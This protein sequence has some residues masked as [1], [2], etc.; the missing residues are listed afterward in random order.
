M[1]KWFNTLKNNVM[2]CWHGYIPNWTSDM[3]KRE[4]KCVSFLFLLHYQTRCRWPVCIATTPPLFHN[5]YA[6]W[7]YL[8]MTR[9]AF[10]RLFYFWLRRKEVTSVLFG[11]VCS[12]LCVYSTLTFLFVNLNGTYSSASGGGGGSDDEW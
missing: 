12:L 10:A 11:Y 1:E 2:L 6:L 4:T 7:L 9:F 8:E 3:T 5:I